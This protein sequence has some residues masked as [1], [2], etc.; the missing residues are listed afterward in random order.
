MDSSDWFE[1]W[2][3]HI[4]LCTDRAFSISS[5]H[6]T[7]DRAEHRTGKKH[8]QPLRVSTEN[9][10]KRFDVLNVLGTG[11]RHV[12]HG[13][14][15]EGTKSHKS[16]T[17]C[18]L[19]DGLLG[20]L[21]PESQILTTVAHRIPFRLNP[22]SPS[23]CWNTS[24]RIEKVSHILHLHG[25]LDLCRSFWTKI[26]IVNLC[27]WCDAPLPAFRR[28]GRHLT[29]NWKLWKRWKKILSAKFIGKYPVNFALRLKH[30]HVQQESS[31]ASLSM[32]ALSMAGEPSEISAIGVLSFQ[33]F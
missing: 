24:Y 2:S 6:E 28:H 21:S 5:H 15:I 17:G 1:S 9:R 11:Q 7:S 22:S 12:I 32:V 18:W 13:K 25:L 20:C 30:C 16:L 19:L 14:V 8:V 4:E 27:G 3:C 23:K 33:I 31:P 29:E 10:T 26:S